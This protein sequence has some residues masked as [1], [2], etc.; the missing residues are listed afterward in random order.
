MMFANTAMYLSWY[1]FAGVFPFGCSGQMLEIN[2]APYSL[3][4]ISQKQQ[5]KPAE[6]LQYATVPRALH[7]VRIGFEVVRS[8]AV[9]WPDQ[10]PARMCTHTSNTMEAAAVKGVLAC[11]MRAPRMAVLEGMACS[12]APLSHVMAFLPSSRSSSRLLRHHTKGNLFHL[13]RLSIIYQTTCEH[14][15]CIL[16]NCP[17]VF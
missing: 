1:F 5:L 6:V 16:I 8:L 17:A 14:Q 10:E 7:H 9:D 15:Q 13:L 2:K 11:G 3:L 4:V 12:H